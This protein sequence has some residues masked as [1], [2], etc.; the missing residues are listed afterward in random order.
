M[1][2]DVQAYIS[3]GNA[4]LKSGDRNGAA[5]AWCR[6]LDVDPHLA[7]A[8]NN[9]GAINLMGRAPWL[10]LPFFLTAT[11][12]RPDQASF[13]IGLA[14]TLVELG[15]P[16]RAAACL[17]KA[18]SRIPEDPALRE[19]CRQCPADA[20]IRARFDGLAD[21]SG[22]TEAVEQL[23]AIGDV[24]P[25][26]DPAVWLDRAKALV[27][28]LPDRPALWIVLSRLA[29]QAGDPVA[30]E[31]NARHAVALAPD[32]SESWLALAGVL[33]QSGHRSEDVVRVLTRAL[34][35]C[36]PRLLL[37][38]ALC[39]RLIA[40]GRAD[41][42]LAVLDRLPSERIGDSARWLLLKARVHEAAGDR[43]TGAALFSDA[44][45]TTIEPVALLLAA[46]EFHERDLKP[47]A[48]LE[49]YECARQAGAPLDQPDIHHALARALFR[50]GKVEAAQAAVRRALD[51]ALSD[52]ARRV[53]GFIAG[54]IADRLGQHD[55]AWRHFVTA[56]ALLEAVWEV[57]G[58]CD[59]TVPLARLASLDQR[60]EAEITS[61]RPVAQTPDD[62]TDRQGG[63]DLAFLVGFPRSGTTLLDSVLRAHSR[64]L[65][66]EEAPV[67]IEAL[68]MLVPGFSGDETLF[69]EDWLDAIAAAEVADLRA[70]YR[71]RLA[72]HAGTVS[73]GVTVIDKLPLNMNWAA[74]IHRIFPAAGFILARR[75]PLDVALSNF[76]QDFA[77]N[78][79]MMVMTRLERI[80]RFHAASFDHWDRFVDWRKPRLAEVRYEA[81]VEDLRSEVAP[82]LSM[83]G[84]E[85]EDGQAR[86]YETARARG[87]ISTPS[88]NQ[89]T[90]P[91]YTR[92]RD[93][94]RNHAEALS[95]PVCE[96]LR[97]RARAWGYDVDP[98][99]ETR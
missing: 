42:A 11:R 25:G 7:T 64:V 46:A 6:A 20:E 56:N 88:A 93:R 74:V 48:W 71:T 9:L 39:N 98:Y 24:P 78:N 47:G 45:A 72:H 43:S 57:P 55:E 22:Q 67:L 12:L 5:L 54:Q 34:V 23:A 17:D 26:S 63:A 40:T 19:A 50:S 75:N 87:R 84:L 58:R 68:R 62:R 33:A 90:Q 14:R 3:E 89:V 66:L 59:H 53:A 97:L 4:C 77:P 35:L 18:A 13:W 29:L 36:G 52:D 1:S 44:L 10:A 69:S 37:A 95:D 60:L 85:W 28:S 32:A 86:F 27:W 16:R 65:V 99:P 81:L 21:R 31:F 76:T 96:P 80:A 8:C 70:A 41:E 94:W 2:D 79:A 82:I 83:L 51:G 49:L 91:L 92:A 61:A 38:E 73:A 30:A 15:E